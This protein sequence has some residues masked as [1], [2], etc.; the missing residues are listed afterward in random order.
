MGEIN[1]SDL[2]RYLKGKEND[3]RYS[4]EY[5]KE[6]GGVG[7]ILH[8]VAMEIIENAEVRLNSTMIL[9]NSNYD[10]VQSQYHGT[11]HNNSTHRLMQ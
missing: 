4:L 6:F 5:L 11:E 2:K 7:P 9:R 1:I 10:F 3:D 8:K